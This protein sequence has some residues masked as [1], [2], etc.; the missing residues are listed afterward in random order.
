MLGNPSDVGHAMTLA[1]SAGSAMWFSGSWQRLLQNTP[2][3][4]QHRRES[5]GGQR[6]NSGY[7]SDWLKV[8]SKLN[9]TSV[10]NVLTKALADV[11]LEWG[12]YRSR[13][14]VPRA[15]VPCAHAGVNPTSPP[16][17]YLLLR[18]SHRG[19]TNT[20]HHWA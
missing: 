2:A 15:A 11:L 5:H 12:L 9:T 1:D 3:C 4:P 20:T 18:I 10:L 17:W 16:P 8:V 19:P 6:G 13:V 7:Y 14:R